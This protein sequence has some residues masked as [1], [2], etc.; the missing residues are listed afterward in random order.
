MVLSGGGYLAEG[1]RVRFAIKE[2]AATKK[3][4]SRSIVSTLVINADMNTFNLSK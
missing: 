1:G 4:L 2:A 3:E